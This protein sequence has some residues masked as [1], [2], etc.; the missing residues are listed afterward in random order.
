MDPKSVPSTGNPYIE[1]ARLFVRA[2][3]RLNALPFGD[4]S[5]QQANRAAARAA[6]YTG[7]RAQLN[8]IGQGLRSNFPAADRTGPRLPQ[9]GQI[10]TVSPWSVAVSARPLPKGPRRRRTP[11]RKPARKPARK[12][13]RRAP[14]LPKLPRIPSP[15]IPPGTRIPR[16]LPNVLPPVLK[17]ILGVLWPSPIKPDPDWVPPPARA[18]PSGPTRRPVVRPSY[19]PAP[20]APAEREPSAP[21]APRPSAPPA[22]AA[23]PAP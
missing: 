12:P 10:V 9:P 3:Q 5:I 11:R 23:P 4:S 6:G 7:T 15:D 13:P 17:V 20:A 19:P 21:P 2:V 22:P 18:R 8:A 16:V 14:R 1:A